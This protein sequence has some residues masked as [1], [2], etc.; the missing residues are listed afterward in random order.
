[1][2]TPA[3]ILEKF[4]QAAEGLKFGSVTMTRSIKNGQHLYKITRQESYVTEE[5]T[6]D[7]KVGSV[8][9]KIK[10]PQ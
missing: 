4:E 2:K 8:T 6:T 5:V 7:R 10:K 3:N 1:M 9:V